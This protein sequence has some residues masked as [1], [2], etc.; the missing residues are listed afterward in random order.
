MYA[1]KKNLSPTCICCI[2]S[3]QKQPEL[4]YRNWLLDKI[5][6]IKS[7]AKEKQYLFSFFFM[8]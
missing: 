1:G 7:W 8:P 5:F 2:E 3:I 4:F 6:R